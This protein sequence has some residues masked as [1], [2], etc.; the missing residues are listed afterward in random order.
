MG[1][2]AVCVYDIYGD[3]VEEYHAD[4]AVARQRLQA[5]GVPEDLWPVDVLAA[6]QDGKSAGHKAKDAV[7]D[8]ID[9][10]DASL[11]AFLAMERA[12]KKKRVGA[13]EG[14]AG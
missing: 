6:G 9:R 10:L 4:L 1:G 13:S 8:E 11:K 12:L 7:D 5:T 14:R 3:A 2:C